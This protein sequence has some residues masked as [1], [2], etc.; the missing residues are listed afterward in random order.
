MSGTLTL[1]RSD[2][3]TAAPTGRLVMTTG[4]IA[5]SLPAGIESLASGGPEVT[6]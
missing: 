2:R 1:A 5:P 3:V 6:S 4:R